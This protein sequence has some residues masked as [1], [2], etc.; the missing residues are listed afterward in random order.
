[1][2][3]KLRVFVSQSSAQMALKTVATAVFSFVR[4]SV[5][6]GMHTAIASQVPLKK[7]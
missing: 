2:S 1:M 7:L 5:C 3:C 4:T 6:S